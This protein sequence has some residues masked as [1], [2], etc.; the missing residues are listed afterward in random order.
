MGE[1]VVFKPTA[2]LKKGTHRL[3]PR[4]NF[5]TIKKVG[6]LFNS[7]PNA[8]VLLLRLKERLS[9]Q[10]PNLEFVYRSKPTAARP[11]VPEVFDAL[12]QCDVVVN[13]FGD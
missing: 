5:A 8:D 11:M 10:Y 6:L 7:K 2:D 12:S 3:A 1:Y 13:A 9:A 4:G